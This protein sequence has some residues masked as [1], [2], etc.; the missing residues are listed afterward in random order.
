MK[1]RKNSI[2]WNLPNV[3]ADWAKQHAGST[4]YLFTQDQKKAIRDAIEKY[5]KMRLSIDEVEKLLLTDFDKDTAERIAYTEITR[6]SAN[7]AQ[8]MGEQLQKELGKV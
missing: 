6:A 4:Y 2:D 3:A 5:Y 8:I 1:S 7:A